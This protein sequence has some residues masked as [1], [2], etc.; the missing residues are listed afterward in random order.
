ML[1]KLL[2]TE[3]I[4]VEHGN[5]QTA[6]FDPKNRVL[7][8]PV[9]RWMDGDVY[10]LLVLHEVSHALNTPADG[11]HSADNSKG[12]GYK[13]FLNVTEDARIEKKIKRKYPGA[14]KAMVLG[15]RELM[16]Q[17][18]FGIKHVNIEKL[19][20]IDRINLHT[21]GGAS[22]GIEFSEEE[23]V[24]VDELM[25]LETF[26]EIVE[27]TNR[28]YDYCAENES[29]T[30][31][32]DMSMMSN[33]Y[34]DSDE[35]DFDDDFDMMGESPAD[36]DEN[37]TE[38]T[39]GNSGMKGESGES[40]EEDDSDGPESES[41]SDSGKSS[42]DKFKDEVEKAMNE[43]RAENESKS[44]EKSE[45]KSEGSNETR[46]T[47][48]AGG[49]GSEVD[50]NDKAGPRSITDEYFRAKEEELNEEI[51]EDKQFIYA[52]LP[53]PDLK[54][55]VWDYKLIQEEF[56]K[57][58]GQ[59]SSRYYGTLSPKESWNT[60]PK[61]FKKF[62]EENKSIIDYLAKEFEMKKRADEYKRTAS[63]NTGLLDTSKLYSYKYSENLFKRVATV[64]SGKNH[65]LVMFIDWSGSMQ[66]NMA[67]TME[68]LMILVMFCRKVHIPFD[69]YAF[70]DRL[71]RIESRLFTNNSSFGESREPKEERKPNWEL[72]PNT[73][74]YENRF[75]LMQLFS[76]K[77]SNTEF[78]KACWN[79]INI[80][81]FYKSRQRYSSYDIV[82]RSP[83]VPNIFGLGGTPLNATIV[84]AHDLIRKFKKDNNVQIVN[85]VFLTD[86]DSHSC[87]AYRDRNNVEKHIGSRDNLTI[88]DRESKTEISRKMSYRHREQTE[89][90]FDSLRKSVGVNIIGFFL[91]NRIDRHKVGMMMPKHGKTSY[92]DFMTMWRKEK[93][94]VTDIDGYDNLYIIKDGA[95]LQ[96]D[97]NSELD[98]VDAGAKKSAIRSAFKKMNRKKLRNRVVL[99][100]FVE[101]VA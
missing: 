37:E 90:L 69:V 40:D 27:Y 83:N 92:D 14:S 79:A 73:M 45:E 54:E 67:G 23:K 49:Y 15:Y 1:A 20:L 68:Q 98:K 17:D 87:N 81:D 77:M 32:H 19:P 10:D 42:A 53:K 47:P 82:S 38:E 96:V 62:R 41:D 85:S 31:N 9:F 5:Y 89:M 94:L 60:A 46:P 50:M 93:C 52:D 58:Y 70:T 6:A 44:E 66:A 39:D 43:M 95:D 30:D 13:S 35:D 63:A 65:G 22:M 72:G 3:N 33:Y 8:L 97:G 34:E 7:Y 80:R 71:C 101:L 55:I 59:E 56:E 25:K 36:W 4:T 2:A 16:R 76:N 26:D 18:F 75:N 21:K 28:L 86:G 78:N 99:N 24:W 100:K 29:E 84:A 74:I 51:D 57:Y 48:T 91:V 11:W 12:K 61:V 64:Q 88:R